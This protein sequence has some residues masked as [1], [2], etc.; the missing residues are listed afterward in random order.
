MQS[1]SAVPVDGPSYRPYRWAGA[2]FQLGLR[3][4][5][6][7]SWILIGPEHTDMMRQKRVRLDE[8]RS[9]YYGSLPGS[10]PAQRELRQRV[11]AHLLADHPSCFERSG[12][13]IRSRRTGQTIDLDDPGTEPL[14][15]LSYLIEE[16]FMLLDEFG[17][18]PRITAASNA[19]STSG[20]L[21]ASVGRDVAWAHEPV[22]RLTDKLGMRINQVIGSIHA[23]SPCERFNWQLTPMATVF[24]PH[25][26]PHAANAAAMH[27]VV[28][29]LRLD[30]ARAGELLWIRV[31]RQTLSRLP[32]SNAVAFS[33]HTYSDP[34]SSVQS[35]VAS[36]RAILTLLQAYSEERWKYSEMD[37][38]RE[39]LMNWLE[40]AANQ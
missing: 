6:P 10:L 40:A 37:I 23:A 36:V 29:T 32:D 17:G 9:F 30:P 1:H 33:L 24:F 21:V 35:E 12:S 22:P 8:Q 5:K 3:R 38:V 20:R 26:D 2:D 27:A 4:I 34:L 7:E 16:D 11:T 28:Q 18:A 31:E 25:D 13:V 19:Y 15:Q 14:L 39:P